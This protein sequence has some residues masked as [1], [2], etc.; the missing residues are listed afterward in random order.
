MKKSILCVITIIPCS[1]AS[2]LSSRC[3]HNNSIFPSLL[4]WTVSKGGPPIN[5]LSELSS[6]KFEAPVPFCGGTSFIVILSLPP[7]NEKTRHLRSEPRWQ[8]QINA[9]PERVGGWQGVLILTLSRAHLRFLA[10]HCLLKCTDKIRWRQSWVLGIHFEI[11]KFGAVPNLSFPL[12]IEK[13]VEVRIC[14]FH[15]L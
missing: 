14:C 1:N 8:H 6:T 15:P 5:L 3:M 2:W 4:M 12:C 10:R 11:E 13:F 7:W 9:A